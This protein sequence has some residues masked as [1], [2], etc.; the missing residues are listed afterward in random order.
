[1][2]PAFKN[3][4]VFSELKH[5]ITTRQGGKSSGRYAG[6]N[7]SFKVGDTIEHVELNRQIV[8]KSFG[9]EP[10]F[11]LFPD[12]CHTANIMI[13]GSN[14]LAEELVDTDALITQATGI[15]IGVLAADC[16][17]ILLYD[18]IRKVIA[19]AHAGWKGTVKSIAAKVVRELVR[20]F[21]SNPA[22]I[23]AGIGPAIS[24]TN[25]E[26]DYHVIHQVKKCLDDSDECYI[27]SIKANHYQLDLQALNCKLL[28]KEGL[29]KS[30]IEILR[31][32]TFENPELFYSARRDGYYTGRFAAVISMNVK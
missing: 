16:V 21:N 8:A 31:L 5:C 29:Q 10:Q 30:N 9:I 19:A 4:S 13:I 20:N 32:C 7:L 18:P 6:L 27:P 11:L 23:V 22:D 14:N 17:P 12:Q 26:V 15:A 25:Y 2:S 28:V 24:Q 3:L 1:M